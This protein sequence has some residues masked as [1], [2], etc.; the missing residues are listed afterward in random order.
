MILT[1]TKRGIALN[2]PADVTAEDMAKEAPI[3]MCDNCWYF[4]MDCHCDFCKKCGKMEVYCGCG[5]YKA[6]RIHTDDESTF[7]IHPTYST[8]SGIL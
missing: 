8:M 2:L 6:V 7:K 4:T 5:F 1:E 3:P